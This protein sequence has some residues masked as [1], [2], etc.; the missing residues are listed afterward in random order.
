[1]TTEEEGW[2]GWRWVG[3]KKKEKK[4]RR[5]EDREVILRSHN[6]YKQSKEN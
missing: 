3:E 1:M 4:G 5:E 2:K 6:I